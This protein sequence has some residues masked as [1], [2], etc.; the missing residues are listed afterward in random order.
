MTTRVEI[1][2][3][4]VNAAKR[5]GRHR[6]NKEVVNAALEEYVQRRGRLQILELR[7]KID[8]FPDYDH[9]RLRRKKHL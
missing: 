3:R 2:S 5:A 8:F 6:T 4:L 9:K 1:D 7:G